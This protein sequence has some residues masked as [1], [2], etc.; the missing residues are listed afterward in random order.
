MVESE[1]S[2]I[3][4]SVHPVTKN[5]NHIIIEAGLGLG[6]AIVQGAITPDSYI[7]EKNNWIILD[8]K[9][10]EQKKMLVRSSS[11]RNEWKEV[12]EEGKK[13][14]LSEK[15][16]VDLAKL[17]IKIE[18]HYGFPVDVEWT[19]EREEFYILQSRPIT[20]LY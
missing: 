16:I 20:A 5:K 19:K 2:G 9:I 3:A 11:G 15:E 1:V 8:K 10:N 6:E 13:Q 7:V 12:G 17:I 4:F 14:V 18:K